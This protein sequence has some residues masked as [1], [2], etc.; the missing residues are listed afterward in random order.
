[1]RPSLV[2]IIAVFFFTGCT[3]IESLGPLEPTDAHYSIAVLPM[4][5]I[6]NDVGGADVVRSLFNDELKKKGHSAMPIKEVDIMLRDQMGITLG[7]QLDMATS[8]QL[9]ETLGVDRLIYGYL[10]NFDDQFMLSYNTRAVRAG[11]KMVDAATGEVVWSR[12]KGVKTVVVGG[13]TG[14]GI[15]VVKEA[16]EAKSKMESFET[17]PGLDDISGIRDW[18]ILPLPLEKAEYA[19]ILTLGAKVLGK[20]LGVHLLYESY[21]VVE[22]IVATMP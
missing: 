5:N 18:Q 21:E 15:A 13:Q 22:D 16:T 6:T 8:M 20:V 3:T 14:V 10:L 12:G 11:F 9:G 19:A 1:M 4:Y 7:S 2:L 17:V